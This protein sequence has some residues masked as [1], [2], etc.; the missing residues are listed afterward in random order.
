MDESEWARNVEARRQEIEPK[1]K[2]A[3]QRASQFFAKYFDSEVMFRDDDLRDRFARW[4]LH[5]S[6]LVDYPDMLSELESKVGAYSN[7]LGKRM[8][9][10]RVFL[11]ERGMGG[12]GA[13]DR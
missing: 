11:Q 10:L 13:S 1:L 3:R 2:V 7:D 4:V 8:E 9:I 6:D 12:P 5:G